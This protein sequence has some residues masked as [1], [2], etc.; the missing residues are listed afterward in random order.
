M[1]TRF[2]TIRFYSSH[3]VMVLVHVLGLVAAA[4]VYYLAYLAYDKHNY[5]LGLP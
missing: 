3:S 5:F 2:H 4:L 1:S